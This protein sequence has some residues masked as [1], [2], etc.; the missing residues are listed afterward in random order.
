MNLLKWVG[1]DTT[2][3]KEEADRRR[4]YE[5]GI[6]EV[7][8]WTKAKKAI[9]ADG[10]DTTRRFLAG[11]EELSQ[12]QGPQGAGVEVM[13]HNM[14]LFQEQTEER[15]QEADYRLSIYRNI[16]LMQGRI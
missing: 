2:Q 14:A 13:R 9:A 12:R 10:E 5:Y 11:I 3:T 15:L 7:K 1:L 8:R 16:V 4:R 6:E